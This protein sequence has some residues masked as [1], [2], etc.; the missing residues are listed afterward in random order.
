MRP[1]PTILGIQGSLQGVGTKVLSRWRNKE[2][3]TSKPG[4]S[5]KTPAWLSVPGGP[6][7]GSFSQMLVCSTL[8]WQFGEVADTETAVCLRLGGAGHYWKSELLPFLDTRENMSSEGRDSR[9]NADSKLEPECLCTKW[10]FMVLSK[11]PTQAGMYA[12]ARILA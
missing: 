6:L 2:A 10:L 3:Y 4:S 1:Y 9:V 12:A 7:A 5:W 11:H 8:W